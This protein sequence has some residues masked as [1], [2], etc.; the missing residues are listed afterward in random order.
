MKAIFAMTTD[1][2]YFSHRGALS[3]RLTSVLILSVFALWLGLRVPVNHPM[4]VAPANPLPN[5]CGH[6]AVEH[7]KQEGLY[8]SL[9]EAVAAARYNADPLPS[10]DAYQ[11][12]NPAQSL[13]ATFTSSGARVM[14]SK[15]GREREL[16]FKLIGYGYGS[17]ITNLDSRNIVASRNRIEREY[18]QS[19]IPESQSAIKE[20]FVNSEAGIEQ[21]FTLPEP[22]PAERDGDE[23]LRVEMEI[24]GDFEPRLDAAGQAVSFDCG[25]GG[26]ELTYNK[27][28]VYDAREREVAARFELEGKRLAV[29]VEDGEAEYPVTIDPLFTQQA[30]LTA[31]GGAANDQFGASVAISGDTVVVGAPAANVNETTS[32]AVYIF[33]RSG[34]TWTQ[35]AKLMAMNSAAFGSFGRSVAIDGNT[36]VVGAPS[37]PFNVFLGTAYVFERS[38]TT[39]TRQAILTPRA[40]EAFVTFGVSVAIDGDTVVVGA[41]FEN[42]AGPNF[43][44]G[45]AY[46]FMRSGTTWPVQ[47]KLMASDGAVLDL[48]GSSVAIDG[49]TVVVGAIG[50]DIPPNENQG[51]AYVFVRDATTWTQ[52]QKLTASDGAA[53]DQFGSSV[54]TSGD[55]VVVGA[56]FDDSF[57]GSAYVFARS[58]TTWSEQQK[59]TASDGAASDQFGFSV[60]TSGVTVMIGAVGA[61]ISPSFDQGAAYVFAPNAFVTVSAA[62][63]TPP[64]APKEIVSGF[65]SSLAS[66]TAAASSVPLPTSLQGTRVIVKDRAGVVR[67]APLYFVSPSQINYQIPAGASLGEATAAVFI[68]TD[69]VALGAVRIVEFAPSIFTLNS[70]GRGPAAALDA[71]NS[72]LEPF[73]ATQANGQPNIIS[74]YGT[75]LG[76]DATDVDGNVSAS[77]QALID[78]NLVTVLY[79]GQAPGLVGG[80]QFNIQLPGGIASGPHRLTISRGGMTSNA[81]TIAIR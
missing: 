5:L 26:G 51:A 47:A 71:I 6:A 22:P 19:A 49:D 72:T 35:Q 37:D 52:Q 8:A 43:G 53:N 81:V 54:T 2:S 17:R 11:F 24:S 46:V 74:V 25:R 75:G 41:D 13:R 40:E 69:L 59:L 36:V 14:S 16:T 23:A 64:V 28:R 70:S 31:S 29:V 60:A 15:G 55:T 4:T 67:A 12:S 10:P 33:V 32:G 56:P 3:L 30:K 62:S 45:A 65:G 78:G 61:G 21:G 39:W 7:L 27:L 1:N 80:N 20:W 58:G 57:R 34:T 73:N 18:S 48:F 66:T 76:A 77:V 50:A 63:Y 38:G 9:A 79:A 44:K 42:T 68:E